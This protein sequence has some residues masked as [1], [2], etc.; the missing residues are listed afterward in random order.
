MVDDV[1]VEDEEIVIDR[2]R[3]PRTTVGYFSEMWCDS[4]VCRNC[5]VYGWFIDCNT[6][7]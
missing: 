7:F 5:L 3:Q 6:E 1:A 2:L 4:L